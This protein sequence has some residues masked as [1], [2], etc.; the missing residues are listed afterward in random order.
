MLGK[1]DQHYTAFDATSLTEAG[2]TKVFGD[3][4]QVPPVVLIEELEK[5]PENSL[6]WLLG[7]MDRRAE[8]RRTNF[9]IGNVK[10]KVKSLIIAT[11]NN[12]TLFRTM[13]AGAL[14]SRFS[15]EIYCPRPSRTIMA[16]IL[17]REV[18]RVGGD[19]AWIEPT[20]KLCFDKYQI[21]D[22]RKIIPVCLCGSNGLLDG[23]YQAAYEGTQEPSDK[24][25]ADKPVISQP[26]ATSKLNE[27]L[28]EAA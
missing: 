19:V 8:I 21:T 23:S 12:M 22:P 2:M 1:E 6:R 7:L 18:D 20:L 27:L 11:V 15:H 9:R 28:Q 26:E 3:M 25:E 13:L 24:V 17:K 16:R 4:A 10:V 14:A 5:A